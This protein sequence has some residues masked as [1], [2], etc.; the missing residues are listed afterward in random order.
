MATLVHHRLLIPWFFQPFWRLTALVWLEDDPQLCSIYQKE[1]LLDQ[2]PK[3]N[4]VFVLDYFVFIRFV[5]ISWDELP[6]I[7]RYHNLSQ[8][9]FYFC[10][11]PEMMAPSQSIH[12]NIKK[13]ILNYDLGLCLNESSVVFWQVYA[14]CSATWGW[15]CISNGLQVLL[16]LPMNSAISQWLGGITNQ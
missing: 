3:Q 7:L 6:T 8:A 15:I 11:L 5:G 13:N 14:S 12:N 2:T 1:N 9:W 10:L 16:Y 4:W